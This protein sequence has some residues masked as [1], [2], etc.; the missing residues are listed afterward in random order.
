MGILEGQRLPRMRGDRPYLVVKVRKCGWFTP[1]ARGSTSRVGR[2]VKERLPHVRIDHPIFSTRCRPG[3]PHADRPSGTA[4]GEKNVTACGIDLW[5]YQDALARSVY[6]HARG[7]T[8]SRMT[9]GRRRVYPREG[10]TYG[11]RDPSTTLIYPHT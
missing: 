6:P 11:P 5:A 8:L 10:S 7:S 3:L 4:T 1:H 9:L 2:T